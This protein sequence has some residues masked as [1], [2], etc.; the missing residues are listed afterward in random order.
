MNLTSNFLKVSLLRNILEAW[1]QEVEKKPPPIS[2]ADAYKV[3]GLNIDDGCEES[4]IRKAYFR[5]AQKYHPDKNPDGREIFEEVN[6]AY[7]FL[8]SK[9][10]RSCDGPD[11]MNI[12]LI[13]KTQSILFSRYQEGKKSK[14]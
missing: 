1:K 8:C 6:K 12:I 13:L 10:S 2:I 3:L 7:E 11:P 4:T 9:S 5:L 14:I